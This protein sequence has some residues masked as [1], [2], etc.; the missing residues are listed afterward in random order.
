M[1]IALIITILG[2]LLFL[3]CPPDAYF[4]RDFKELGKWAFIIGLAAV[5]C[6]GK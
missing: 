6:F 1:T 5:L 2:C 4:G 3:I